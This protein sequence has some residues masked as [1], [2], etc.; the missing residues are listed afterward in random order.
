[1]Q[2]NVHIQQSLPRVLSKL[3]SINL[4]RSLSR[5]K[6]V[7]KNTIGCSCVFIVCLLNCHPSG[8]WEVLWINKSMLIIL[9]TINITLWKWSLSSQRNGH[10]NWEDL[11][12]QRI[13]PFETSSLVLS[14]Y[15]SVTG[16]KRPSSAFVLPFSFW[17]DGA[18]THCIKTSFGMK[19][20][21]DILEGTAL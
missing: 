8:L 18:Q 11:E 9:R 1:M 3:I 19:V 14:T 15:T 2:A 10:Y 4:S 13:T 20:V 6:D 21:T 12:S 16:I 17:L 7:R 5:D